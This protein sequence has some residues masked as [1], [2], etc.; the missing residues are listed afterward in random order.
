[1]YQ[2]LEMIRMDIVQLETLSQHVTE[3]ILYVLETLPS[4]GVQPD[5][6]SVP[7]FRDRVMQHLPAYLEE[8]LRKAIE[9]V[10]GVQ[11]DYDRYDANNPKNEMY[12]NDD[13]GI[14]THNEVY[15]LITKASKVKREWHTAIRDPGQ[16]LDDKLHTKR[17]SDMVY[18][19]NEIV[20]G[21]HRRL[22][23]R[24]AFFEYIKG[25]ISISKK[26][27][28]DEESWNMIHTIIKAYTRPS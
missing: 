21:I 14:L 4:L 24:V 15:L 19:T 8:Q 1:M 3:S 20:N 9:N 6:L 17:F 23:D 22:P 27:S 28:T 5:D 12:T 7:K 10:K 25:Y 13:G 16:W 18:L 11:E 26:P 2:T